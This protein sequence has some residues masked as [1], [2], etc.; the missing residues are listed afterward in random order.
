MAVQVPANPLRLASYSTP[1]QLWVNSGST[2]SLRI[3][4]SLSSKLHTP[5]LCDTPLKEGMATHSIDTLKH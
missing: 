4:F 3:F 2:L 1:T 5:P